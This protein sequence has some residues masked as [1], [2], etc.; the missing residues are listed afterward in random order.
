MDDRTKQE[1]PSKQV[2]EPDQPVEEQSFFQGRP[3][4]WRGRLQATAVSAALLAFAT[5]SPAADFAYVAV[6]TGLQIFEI[7]HGSS[8]G[9]LAEVT[10]L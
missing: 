2:D 7:D 10:V 3:S 9:T 6:R 8:L 5:P 1:Q 4:N